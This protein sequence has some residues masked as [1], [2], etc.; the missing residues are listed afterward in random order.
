MLKSVA[1]GVRPTIPEAVSLM[2]PR[3]SSSGHN[4]KVSMLSSNCLQIFFFN[5]FKFKGARQAT[6]MVQDKLK[7]FSVAHFQKE[8]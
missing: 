7:G 8:R 4:T 1:V 3:Q 2:G 6:S 5:F